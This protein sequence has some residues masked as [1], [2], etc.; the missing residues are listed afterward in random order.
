MSIVVTDNNNCHRSSYK[1]GLLRRM[2]ELK[3]ILKTVP[4]FSGG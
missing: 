4:V 1:K 2:K 3:P